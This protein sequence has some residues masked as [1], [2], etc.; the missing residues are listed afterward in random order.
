MNMHPCFKHACACVHDRTCAHKALKHHIRAHS[1]PVCL[2]PVDLTAPFV[3]VLER[4]KKDFSCSLHC[5]LPFYFLRPTRS[6]RAFCHPTGSV[7]HCHGNP[8]LEVCRRARFLHSEGVTHNVQAE[9]L[10]GQNVDKHVYCGAEQHSPV[11]WRGKKMKNTV[12]CFKMCWQVVWK[13][14]M[15][16]KKKHMRENQYPHVNSVCRVYQSQEVVSE[17]NVNKMC[18]KVKENN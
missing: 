2:P 15:L 11:Q 4:K 1:Q 8:H 5:V 12:E 17:R 14:Q 16:V 13:G 18:T 3:H 9:S 6:N 7:W 10:L